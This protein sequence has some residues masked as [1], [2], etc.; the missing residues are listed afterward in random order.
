[1]SISLIPRYQY[2]SVYAPTGPFDALA[3]GINIGDSCSSDCTI[4]S[5]NRRWYIGKDSS[6]E[7]GGNLGGGFQILAFSDTGIYL[8]A[9]VRI[10]RKNTPGGGSITVGGTSG[11]RTL[12]WTCGS[13]IYRKTFS[14]APYTVLAADSYVAQVG[15]MTA[16][17]IVTLPKITGAGGAGT[18]RIYTI[19]DESG[20]VTGINTIVVTCNVADTING[21]ASTTINTAYGVVRLESDGVSK[22]TLI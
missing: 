17:R 8:D 19:Y 4:G 9:P 5:P 11:S 13:Q 3:C 22:W 20:S 1:M 7:P 6:A 15:A 12:Q 16:S 18:G 14:N 10:D 2:F 21:A